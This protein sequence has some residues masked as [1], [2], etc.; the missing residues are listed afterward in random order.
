MEA[1]GAASNRA[2]ANHREARQPWGEPA[3][4]G[5][6]QYPLVGWAYGWRFGVKLRV[7]TQG[8]LSAS[9]AGNREW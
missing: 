7:L 3:Q 6:P 1:V 2:K 9:A 4:G 5:E 8:D